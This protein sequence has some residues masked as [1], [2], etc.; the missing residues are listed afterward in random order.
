[1]QCVLCYQGDATDTERFPDEHR[2]T[3]PRCG[4]YAAS[5][6]AYAVLSPGGALDKKLDTRLHLTWAARQ[7]SEFGAPLEFSTE[8]IEE[9]ARSVEEPHPPS[10]K[11]DQLILLLGNRAAAYGKG[12]PLDKAKDWPLVF[13]R[14]EVEFEALA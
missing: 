7:A 9:I 8:N 5:G 2:I 10:R 14:G 12:V 4:T 13:A 1:M 6:R 3:C 11:L